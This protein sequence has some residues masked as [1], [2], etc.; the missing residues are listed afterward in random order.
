MKV[1]ISIPAY[2]EEKT[3]GNV[4]KDIKKVMEQ[5]HYQYKIMVVNDG[6]TDKTSAIA[7]QE[8]ALVFD[9]PRNYGLAET[10][11]TEIQQALELNFDVFVHT[12]ADGQYRAEDI[13][14][15]IKEIEQGNDLVLG[16]RFDGGIEEMPLLKKIGNKAFSR[17]I[18]NILRYHVGDCQT[19]FRAF[20]RKVAEKIPINSTFTYTQE[21]IIRAVKQKFRVKEIPTRFLKRGGKTS[22]RLMK[23]PFD[24]AIKAWINILRIYRDYEPLKFFGWIGLFFIAVGG[25]V[26][27]WLIYLFITTGAIRRIPTA[28]LSVMF[29]L[30]GIQI[31]L[32]GFLADMNKDRTH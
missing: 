19:G 8:G 5:H 3:I 21:Q 9:H 16:N 15:L 13:P 17:A 27:L 30:I 20:T 4:I 23:N 11:R 25:G 29:V 18:S 1:L 2:N 10:F 22:S 24:Y 31:L 32:F 7:K 14:R 6:S 26:G 28:I 12:D